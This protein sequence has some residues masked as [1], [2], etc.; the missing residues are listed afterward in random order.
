MQLVVEGH[1]FNETDDTTEQNQGDEAG[2]RNQDFA[3]MIAGRSRG[4]G[5]GPASSGRKPGE[6]TETGGST[7]QTKGA[8]RSVENRQ[9]ERTDGARPARGGRGG[10]AVGG[11]HRSRGKEPM[12]PEALEIS[13]AWPLL[14]K[15]NQDPRRLSADAPPSMCAGH[16]TV[17]DVTERGSIRLPLHSPPPVATPEEAV[18]ED[19]GLITSTD[20]AWRTSS[21]GEQAHH[22]RDPDTSAH[23]RLVD[24]VAQ[25]LKA[26]TQKPPDDQ[27]MDEASSEEEQGYF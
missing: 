1:D 11:S 14:S 12:Y 10:Y 20:R 27:T 18:R 8:D 19:Q 22:D 23:A 2:S 13:E 7:R 4:R 16:L 17:E 26:K 24:R 9:V 3:W 5:R 15:P 21:Q 25:A 6:S